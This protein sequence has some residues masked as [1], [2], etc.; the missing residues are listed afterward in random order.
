MGTAT[1]L[2]DEGTALYNKADIEGFVSLYS[3]DVVLT[4]PDGRFE[5][6]EAVQ[7]YVQELF[8]AFPDTQVAVG[9]RCEGEDTYFGEFTVTGTNTGPLRMPDGSE[10]P[11]TQKQGELRGMEIA[12]VRNGK[13]ARHDM[14]W[15]SMSL[16][17]QLGLAPTP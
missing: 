5:G 12:E 15:D 13:I 3:E 11:P 7:G 16:L 4:T 17:T 14:Y 2:V 9:R 6:H 1:Q 10:L 8:T